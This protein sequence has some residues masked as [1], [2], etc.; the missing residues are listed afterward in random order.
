MKQNIS[1]G[2]TNVYRYENRKN[3]NNCIGPKVKKSRISEPEIKVP[4]IPYT[5]VGN[6]EER[7]AKLPFSNERTN[8]IKNTFTKINNTHK[9]EIFKRKHEEKISKIIANKK[10]KIYKKVQEYRLKM[11]YVLTVERADSKGIP[12]VFSTNYSNKPLKMLK[13]IADNLGKDLANNWKDFRGV[14]IYKKENLRAGL[15]ANPCE[16]AFYH[17]NSTKHAA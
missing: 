4:G 10:A 5:A 15:K 3:F 6:K 13:V 7:L 1:K 11:P 17:Y 12:Y 8:L 16:H 9:K 14:Y 2:K